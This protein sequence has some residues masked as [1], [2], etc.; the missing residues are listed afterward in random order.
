MTDTIKP[1]PFAKLFESEE[2]GQILVMLQDVEK[3]PDDDYLAHEEDIEKED[4]GMEVRIFF[5]PAVPSLGVASVAFQFVDSEAGD[6]RAR[7]AL[8]ETTQAQAER[9]IAPTVGMLQA[10]FS[11]DDEDPTP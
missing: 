8:Q 6:T 7:Q 10:S 9:I 1:Q 5:D 11:D 4:R 3:D 2:Y